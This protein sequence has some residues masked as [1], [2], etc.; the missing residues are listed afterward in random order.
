VKTKVYAMNRD[1]LEAEAAVVE[2]TLSL[3]GRPVN[4]LID[5]G[6]THSYVSNTCACLMN[7]DGD[8]LPY[9]L[10]ISTPLGRTV[11]ACRIALDC[12]IQVGKYILRGDRIL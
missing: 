7:W 9:D 8:E 4:V 11:V 5:P 1:E 10:L 3:H 2:G 6:S 12:G